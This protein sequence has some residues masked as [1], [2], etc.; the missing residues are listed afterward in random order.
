[1]NVVLPEP[2]APGD[3]DRLPSPDGRPK[4]LLE[5]GVDGADLN[6]SSRA[7][8]GG[9]RCLRIRTTGRCETSMI[10][11]SRA[12]FP[13]FRWSTGLALENDRSLPPR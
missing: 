10:A 8:P 11:A 9:M 1:M 13:R 3:H 6:A 2:W 12:R 4:E 5:D 7:T